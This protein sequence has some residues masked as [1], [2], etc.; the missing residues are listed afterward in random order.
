MHLCTITAKTTAFIVYHFSM[1]PYY[2]HNY[3]VFKHLVKMLRLIISKCVNA[4]IGRLCC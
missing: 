1:H 2:Q 4:N 3:Y